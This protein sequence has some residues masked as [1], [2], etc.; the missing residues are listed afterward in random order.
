M[1]PALLLLL[2]LAGLVAALALT[3]WHLARFP[4]LVEVPPPAHGPRVSILLPARNEAANIEACLGTLMAQD[5]PDLEILILDDHSTD[6]TGDLA[7]AMADER[8][9]VLAGKD[10][11]DG[12]AGKPWACQ[13]L[14][15]AATGGWL[16]F[17]DADTRHAPGTV[18]AAM[19]LCATTRP[20]LLTAWPRHVTITWGEKAL[21]PL[22]YLF[23]VV[24]SPPC[25]FM[26]AQDHPEFAARWFPYGLSHLGTANG[27][28]MLF[29]RSGYDRLGGH[30]AHR[31]QLLE[32][33]S[34]A[35]AVA[36]RMG[37]G[38]RLINADGHRFVSCRMYESTRAVWNG[39]TRS[40][41]SLYRGQ[42]RY[43]PVVSAIS[44]GSLFLLPFIAACV[45]GRWQPLAW[46]EVGLIYLIRLLLALRHRTS[47]AGALLH[48]L[49]IAMMHLIGIRSWWKSTRGGVEW[50][51][52]SYVV[53]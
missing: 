41:H 46:V 45:P 34:F 43:A 3:L 22:M 26:H 47:M 4:V 51:G 19:A 9:R 48:P 8:V 40:T 18:S 20:D 49:A 53:K 17:I 14:A 42:P 13:Q 38:M 32:D 12:W 24:F 7:R 15:D 31:D 1:I 11:P 30:A 25:L 44:V 10:L 5:W 35:R 2:V 36:A 37:E 27:P 6:G 23:A 16:L 33:V 28:F 29:S 21:V 50:R 39:F 52:R